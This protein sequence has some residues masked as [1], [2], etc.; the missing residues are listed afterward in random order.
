[1][2]AEDLDGHDWPIFG[3]GYVGNTETWPADNVCITNVLIPVDP[4]LKTEVLSSDVLIDVDIGG[5]YFCLII[6][7]H[8][9]LADQRP[10]RGQEVQD[11]HCVEQMVLDCIREIQAWRA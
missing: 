2:Y 3:S 9:H 7:S 10:V 11:L 8:E 1:M 5:E 6:W 4:F